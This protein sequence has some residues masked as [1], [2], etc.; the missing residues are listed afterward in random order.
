M[1]KFGNGYMKD[2]ITLF[3]QNLYIFLKKKK[4]AWG[5]RAH[6]QSV[7]FYDPNTPQ[8]QYFA[9]LIYYNINHPPKGKERQETKLY[10]FSSSC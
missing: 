1:I 9:K 2:N 10:E 3:S 7:N 4:K 6:F 5:K 8:K